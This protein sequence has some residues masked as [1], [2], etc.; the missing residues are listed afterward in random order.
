MED[1]GELGAG[2]GAG[3]PQLAS[4]GVLQLLAD[5]GG[6]GEVKAGRGDVDGLPEQVHDDVTGAGGHGAGSEVADQTAVACLGLV[7]HDSGD[8]EVGLFGVLNG[9]PL[10]S[11]KTISGQGSK[12][13]GLQEETSSKGKGGSGGGDENAGGSG[14]GSKSGEGQESASS[15]SLSGEGTQDGG[16]GAGGDGSNGQSKADLGVHAVNKKT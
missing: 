7:G 14:S 16:S 9:E 5:L 15:D 4:V 13:G 3:E 2:Q 11:A 6:G 10:P 8:H 12:G 1:L